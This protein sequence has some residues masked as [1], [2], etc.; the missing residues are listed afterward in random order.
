MRKILKITKWALYPASFVLLAGCGN[1]TP[2]SGTQLGHTDAT[3]ASSSPTAPVAAMTPAP[4]SA[5]PVATDPVPSDAQ[6]SDNCNLDAVNGSGDMARPLSRGTAAVLSGWF[7]DRKSGSVPPNIQLILRGAKIFTINAPTGYSRPDVA[8]A[9]H[10]PAF[11][12]S[13]FVVKADLQAVDLGS[14]GVE[15]LGKIGAK[16]LICHTNRTLNIGS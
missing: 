1:S 2:E 16:T 5:T 10:I 11:S 13:G 6:S 4:A 7:A 12:T 8:N 14:Y 9:Q 3:A 15:V